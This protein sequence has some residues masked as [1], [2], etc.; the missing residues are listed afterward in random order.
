MQGY[1]NRIVNYKQIHAQAT[2]SRKRKRGFEAL[3]SRASRSIEKAKSGLPPPP[4]LVF[5][6][7]EALV[8]SRYADRTWVVKGEADAFCAAAAA[9]EAA[10]EAERNSTIFTNDS[11]LVLF[12]FDVPV[13]VAIINELK[14]VGGPEGNLLELYQY[15]IQSMT[16]KERKTDWLASAFMMNEHQISLAE[17]MRRSD[18]VDQQSREYQDFKAPYDLVHCNAELYRLRGKHPGAYNSDTDSRIS[19]PMQQGNE[20]CLDLYLP[21]VCEDPTRA[22][23]WKIGSE[24]REIAMSVLVL[25]SPSA[26]S[27][28]EYK[29]SGTRITSTLH[30]GAS[31]EQTHGLARTMSEI[32]HIHL[33][34]SP[35]DLAPTSQWRLALMKLVLQDMSRK[36]VML[37]PITAIINVLLG[38]DLTSWED[39]HLA[40]QFQAMYYSLRILQ[41]VFR[42]CEKGSRPEGVKLATQFKEDVR[43]LPRIVD[44]FMP[45]SSPETEPSQVQWRTLIEQHREEVNATGE[46]EIV[47]S[48][49]DSDNDE[50]GAPRWSGAANNPFGILAEAT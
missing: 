25:R 4:F 45:N 43:H 35:P 42:V 5:A 2:K 41:Q 30:E 33:E 1:V 24:F 20:E 49:L 21:V 48:L 15:D 6:V 29:R 37:P 10:G 46:N 3:D 38:G 7:V 12:N 8:S 26:S 47:P 16:A 36:G 18:E 32:L 34:S 11:D 22:S 31:A 9:M 17:A 40:A 50:D 14:E 13:K 28:N 19:E 23:S 39:V 27:F 44:F